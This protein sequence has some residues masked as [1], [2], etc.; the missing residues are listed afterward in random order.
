MDDC[1]LSEYR[2]SYAFDH[3]NILHALNYGK[4]D[5]GSFLVT[6]F[7]TGGSISRMVGG[8][9]ESQIW[10]LI[11]EVA[12]GLSYLHHHGYIHSDIKPDNILIDEDG[13]FCIADFGCLTKVGSRNHRLCGTIVYMPPERHARD[14]F[15][16][17]AN[18]TWSLGATLC[19]LLTG[20]LP[21]EEGGILQQYGMD[22]PSIDIDCSDKLKTTIIGCLS[23]EPSERPTVEQLLKIAGCMRGQ[24]FNNINQ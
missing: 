12:S 17:F 8:I 18:D 16:L 19:E 23:K 1:L 20:D 7:C 9:E 11:Y 2:N 6:K 10:H 13:I 21:F 3:P 4:C 14:V 5:K 22:I 15:P 24:S